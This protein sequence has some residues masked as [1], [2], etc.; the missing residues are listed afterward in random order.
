MSAALKS[1]WP[2][3]RAAGHAGAAVRAELH[4]LAPMHE[5]AW[6]YAEEAGPGAVETNMRDEV[7]W[8]TIEDARMGAPPSLDHEGF[9]FETRESAVRNFFD[10][11]EVARV[12]D[13]EV[14]TLLKARTGASRILIFDHTLRRRM[15][16]EDNRPGGVRPPAMRVHVD[17]TEKSARRRVRDLLPT[18]ASRLLA[19]R[20]LFINV[21]RPI[22]DTVYDAPL[23]LCDAGSV[24]P[25]DLVPADLVYS[26]RTGEIY[27]VTYNARHRR[28]YVPRMQPQEVI[29]LK[30]YDSA[31]DGRARLTPHAAFLDPTAPPQARPRQSIEVRAIAFFD[32]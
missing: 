11:D 10:A 28:L 24:A 3:E 12:Y 1:T 20:F 23:A 15:A 30:N 26:D 31:N 4:Y 8:V 16:T 19:Q 5:R 6:R 13:A 18:E 22:G 25:G 17:Y 27:Y 7:H 2:A 32:A 21:W 29:L 9:T 14:E